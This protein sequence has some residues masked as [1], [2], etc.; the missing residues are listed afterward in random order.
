MVCKSSDV[1]FNKKG[2]ACISDKAVCSIAGKN[3]HAVTFFKCI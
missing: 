3:S 1:N 2:M